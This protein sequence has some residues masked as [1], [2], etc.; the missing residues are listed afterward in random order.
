VPTECIYGE[1]AAAAVELEVDSLFGSS[2]S[3]DEDE[4]SDNEEDDEERADDATALGFMK[5]HGVDVYTPEEGV[6]E[7]ARTTFEAGLGGIAGLAA[8]AASGVLPATSYVYG[9][10][11]AV[12]AYSEM[13]SGGSAGVDL[14]VPVFR[15][16]LEQAKYEFESQE[17]MRAKKTATANKAMKAALR[18][19]KQ[20]QARRDLPSTWTA[21]ML[22][23]RSARSA[24]SSLGGCRQRA[25]VR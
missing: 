7:L 2:S 1:E 24:L 19:A 12:G 5:S 8:S 9:Y 21:G 4:S 16:M 10:P 6:D 14:W 13:A 23:L 11:N 3:S 18:Q 20:R 17:S 22:E 15:I 25:R